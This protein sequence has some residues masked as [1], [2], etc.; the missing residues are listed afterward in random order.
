MD[1]QTET[2]VREWIDDLLRLLGV[3]FKKWGRIFPHAYALITCDPNTGVTLPEPRLAFLR[4]ETFSTRAEQ[5]EFFGMLATLAKRGRAV[6]AAMISHMWGTFQ[7][8]DVPWD[9]TLPEDNPNRVELVH[10]TLQHRRLQR[11]WVAEISRSKRGKPKLG[12]FRELAAR[13]VGPLGAI[14]E[15]VGTDDKAN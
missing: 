7:R 15:I 12:V 13:A 9:G 6:G 1:L 10:V 3:Q 5:V 11:M 8:D 4:A 14:R 2:G